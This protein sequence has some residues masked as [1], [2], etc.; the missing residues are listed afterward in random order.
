MDAPYGCYRSGFG[1]RIFLLEGESTE[2]LRTTSLEEPSISTTTSST[3]IPISLTRGSSEWLIFLTE[4]IYRQINVE[5]RLK[6]LL[7]LTQ[8]PALA[9]V[10]LS[11]NEYM[12]L[13]NFFEHESLVGQDATERGEALGCIGSK[14]FGNFFT[15]GIGENIFQGFLYSSFTSR[16]RNYVALDELAVR[17]VLEWMN[18]P[19][20]RENILTDIYDREG[21]GIVIGAEK[22]V[23]VTQNFC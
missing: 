7:V 3:I 14:D 12:A 11:H 15:E 23:W 18:R 19:G 10:A 5:R 22:S 1:S 17:V 9:E 21:L 16:S 4:K 20:H 2:P 6:S 13:N 8:D